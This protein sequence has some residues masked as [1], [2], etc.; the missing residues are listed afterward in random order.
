MQA[1]ILL[2]REPKILREP[3]KILGVGRRHELGQFLTPDP[4]ADFMASLFRDCHRDVNLLDAG[5]G[6]GALSAAL[7]RRLC[8]EGRRPKRIS[9]TAFEIDPIMLPLLRT[10]LE[11]YGQT[12]RAAGIAFSAIVFNED[13]IKAA[14]AM[15]GADLFATS[16]LSFNA[17]DYH[18][19]SGG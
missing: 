5:A 19:W 13:F 9:V 1:N 2:Q 17:P 11:Q 6:T 8:R 18:C 4:I 10:N 3:E 14:T 15:V 16:R 7:V 12:C